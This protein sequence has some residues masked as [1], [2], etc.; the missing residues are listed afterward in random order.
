MNTALET[1]RH[2][3]VSGCQ[4]PRARR[5]WCKLHYGRWLRS[6]DPNSTSRPEY[7]KARR[8]FVDVVLPY[9]GADCLIWPFFRDDCGRGR[10]CIDGRMVYAARA[11]CENTH[12]KPSLPDMQAAHSCGNGHLGCV[13]PHHLSWKTRA[14]NEADKISHGT[15][16]RGSK[17]GGAKLT[18]SDVRAIRAMSGRVPTP[19]IARRYGVCKSTVSNILAG[20]KWSWLEGGTNDRA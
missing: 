6:G 1:T 9:Q 16:A 3:A 7:G 8:F 11:V 17:N 15:T 20:R 13:N 2:C 18:A 14:E 5:E 12:G 19:A 4:R 10:F